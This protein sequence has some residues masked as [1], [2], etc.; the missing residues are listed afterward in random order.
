MFFG[1]NV[2]FAT[3]GYLLIVGFEPNP[4]V[5][6]PY[7]VMCGL[8]RPLTWCIE[9][10]N[11]TFEQMKTAIVSDF[12]NQLVAAAA[13]VLWIVGTVLFWGYH[14]INATAVMLSF[15][16]VAF[17]GNIWAQWAARRSALKA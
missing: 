6:I 10:R 4:E 14:P 16:A 9:F 8:Y 13:L 5:V 7:L 12:R 15:Y 11:N 1:L 3:F 2:V 17:A